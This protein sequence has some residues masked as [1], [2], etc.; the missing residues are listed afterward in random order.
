VTKLTLNLKNLEPHGTCWKDYN[1]EID[2]REL[3]RKNEKKRTADL[4]TLFKSLRRT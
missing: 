2:E 4:R 3:W 1:S